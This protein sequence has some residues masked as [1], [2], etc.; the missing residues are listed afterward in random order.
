VRTSSASTLLRGP[1]AQ[2]EQEPNLCAYDRLAGGCRHDHRMKG[3]TDWRLEQPRPGTLVWTAPSGLFWT[4][5]PA[6]HAA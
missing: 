3:S 6:P 5:T 2:D 1:A 4:V